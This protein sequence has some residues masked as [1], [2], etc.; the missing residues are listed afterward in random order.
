MLLGLCIEQD[1]S[2]IVSNCMIKRRINGGVH[3]FVSW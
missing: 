2:K 1:I 3:A